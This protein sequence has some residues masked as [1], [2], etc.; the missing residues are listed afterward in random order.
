[1]YS[2]SIFGKDQVSLH[3][4]VR[5]ELQNGK[6]LFGKENG[7]FPRKLIFTLSKKPVLSFVCLPVFEKSPS[8]LLFLLSFWSKIQLLLN[9]T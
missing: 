1:M 8:I 3:S 6:S 5:N 2:L 4:W 9:E 7:F